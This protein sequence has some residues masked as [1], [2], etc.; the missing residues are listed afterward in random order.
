MAIVLQGLE[1][2]LGALGLE[3]ISSLVYYPYF[4]MPKKSLAPLEVYSFLRALKWTYE[5]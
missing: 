3:S 2:I 4:N 5:F 1:S